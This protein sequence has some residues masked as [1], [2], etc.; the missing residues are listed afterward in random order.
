MNFLC[1]LLCLCTYVCSG[2]H[3]RV[4]QEGRME[5]WSEKM[6]TTYKADGDL[7]RILSA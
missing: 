7:Q 2:A 1:L 6:L 5:G 4:K 3:E